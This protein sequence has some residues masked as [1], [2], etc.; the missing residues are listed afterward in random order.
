[1]AILKAKLAWYVVPGDDAVSSTTS[2]QEATSGADDGS[3]AASDWEVSKDIVC[4]VTLH[5]LGEVPITCLMSHQEHPGKIWSFLH[6][7][8]SPK[9]TFNKAALHSTLARL[10]YIGQPMHEYVTKWELYSV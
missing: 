6:E 7:R 10:R 4:S 3:V 1:M 8:Y 5:G 9:T 2:H